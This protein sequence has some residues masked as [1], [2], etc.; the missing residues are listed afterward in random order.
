MGSSAPDGTNL[1]TF[2]LG[3]ALTASLELKRRTLVD[4]TAALCYMLQQ[5]KCF[6]SDYEGIGGH[7]AAVVG[8]LC[9]HIVKLVN[10]WQGGR[11]T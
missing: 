5:Y 8:L 1:R 10:M 2:S 9:I 3:G 11:S 7:R 6:A 4:K